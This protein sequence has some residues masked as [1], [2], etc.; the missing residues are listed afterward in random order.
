[1]LPSTPVVVI[2]S[3]GRRVLRH[4]TAVALCALVAHAV[5]YGSLM[6]EDG[7]HG[8]FT[9]YAPLVG[10]LSA[11]SILVTSLAFLIALVSPASR[12]DVVI[13][14][15]LPTRSAD[16]SVFAELFRLAGATLLFLAVQESLERSLSAGRLELVSFAPST[17]V[18]LVTAVLFAAA[19]IALAERALSSLTEIVLRGA[20]ATGR[21]RLRRPWPPAYL[22]PRARLRPLAVHGGLRAPP[23]LA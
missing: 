5:A 20:R 7:A 23:L 8:Y 12:F 11:L 9:W 2:A 15:I 16:R 21:K 17:L 6:P 13:R 19:A 18:F 3:H 22:V 10:A 14:S 1:V 4:V